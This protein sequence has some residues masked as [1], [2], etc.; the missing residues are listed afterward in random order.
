[1]DFSPQGTGAD[2]IT[3]A[4][5]LPVETRQEQSF[6]TMDWANTPI[7]T[8]TFGTS[9]A[10]RESPFTPLTCADT[11]SPAEEGGRRSVWISWSRTWA[12]ISSGSVN[13]SRSAIP[14]STVTLWEALWFSVSL[15]PAP[16][17]LP[18]APS[19]PLVLHSGC[20]LLP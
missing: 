4:G 9:S 11:D 18:Y 2:S 16:W 13:T 19:R 15:S 20:L 8:K 3:L 1:M 10:D 12:I 6:F 14:F 5:S 17:V 7:A